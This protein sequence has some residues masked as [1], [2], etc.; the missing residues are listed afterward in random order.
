MKKTLAYAAIIAS[1]ATPASAQGINS[2]MRG[3]P[4]TGAETDIAKARQVQVPGLELGSLQ[5]SIGSLERRDRIIKE[6]TTEK[7]VSESIPVCLTDTEKKCIPREVSLVIAKDLRAIQTAITD[8]QKLTRSIQGEESGETGYVEPGT[9][10]SA[11]AGYKL[12]QLNAQ[13]FTVVY[14]AIDLKALEDRQVS[15]PGSVRAVIAVAQ[16]EVLE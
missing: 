11:R 12:G 14:W 15:V 3:A 6:G 5:A 13:M 7:Q 4:A 2:L 9:P 10:A 8:L 1:L 16:P